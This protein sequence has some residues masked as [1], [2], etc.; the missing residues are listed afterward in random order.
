MHSAQGA[1]IADR[2][3]GPFHVV[4]PNATLAGPV[5]YRGDLD[6][7][8][9]TDGTGY[10]IYTAGRSQTMTVE[11]LTPDFTRSTLRSTW[12]PTGSSRANGGGYE[13]STGCAAY[14]PQPSGNRSCSGLPGTEGSRWANLS[15]GLLHLGVDVGAE[16]PAMWRNGSSSGGLYFA[17]FDQ[18]CGF[19][20][21]GSGAWVHAAP[22]PLGPWTLHRNINR[23][24]LPGCQPSGRPASING[25]C[26]RGGYSY[27]NANGG[28]SGGGDGEQVEAAPV[29]QQGDSDAE[30]WRSLGGRYRGSMSEGG[31]DA[32]VIEASSPPNATQA[33][34]IASGFK[35]GALT[36]SFTAFA[37]TETTT[38]LPGCRSATLGR[39]N[40]SAPPCSAI[41]FPN[42]DA[43]CR[44]SECG[45]C[46]GWPRCSA[47]PP[48]PDPGHGGSAG[49]IIHAQQAGVWPIA[50]ANGET[51]WLWAGDL[52]H[53]T[54]DGLKG[55][56]RLYMGPMT[57]D[58]EGMPLPL[59]YVERFELDIATTS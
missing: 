53:S 1:A 45:R 18:N 49:T 4:T 27:A 41:L 2:P 59:E 44:E 14:Q 30:C 26:G 46:S 52:W 23:R 24:L 3:G 36:H 58:A 7:F 48:P 6:V 32:I 17:T 31:D 33:S 21:G 8:V 20:K 43:W 12:D 34:Y 50:L 56:D 37:A 47:P 19:C 16:A 13:R 38:A 35:W 54:P 25:R 57:F 51:Q 5:D 39:W 9:D 10:L 29:A 22:H 55:H 28:G 15:S 42:H 40:A 11:Q